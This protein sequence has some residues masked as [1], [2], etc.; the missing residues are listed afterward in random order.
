[1]MRTL[2]HLTISLAAC[3]PISKMG[4]GDT[5]GTSETTVSTDSV[6]PEE[7]ISTAPTD[8][9]SVNASVGSTS[10][11][12]VESGDPGPAHC[13]LFA[14]DCPPEQKCSFFSE[15]IYRFE[16]VPTCVP[17]APNP[18]QP[19]QLCHFNEPGM[20]LDDCGLGSYCLPFNSDGAG[21]SVCVALCQAD[22]FACADSA[23]ACTILN[24]PLFWCN[25]NCDPLAQDCAEGL[26]CSLSDCMPVSPGYFDRPPGMPCET[27]S[28][29]VPKSI[30]GFPQYVPECAGDLCCTEIC[31]LEAASSCAL[32]GQSCQPVPEAD[33]LS[34]LLPE[35]MGL[36]L[37]P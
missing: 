20:G 27:F 21:A 33:L 34:S 36:C 15:D 31:D 30:C 10:T 13:D 2:G 12:E 37:I 24:G 32:Q 25:F 17:V 8:S 22:T 7:T 26:A 9:N 16:P 14:Q 18:R 4:S 23:H 19:D 6:N 11:G 28:Q 1:M 5:G 35:G 3:G 29:C